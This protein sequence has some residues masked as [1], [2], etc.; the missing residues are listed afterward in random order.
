MGWATFWATFSQTRHVTLASEHL[1]ISF[2]SFC[3]IQIR[4]KKFRLIS[5]NPKCH[6]SFLNGPPQKGVTNSSSKYLVHMA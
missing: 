2:S 5:L 6:D 3:R 1:L 4:E